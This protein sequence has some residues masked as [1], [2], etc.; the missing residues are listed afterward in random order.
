MY[1]FKPL[2]GEKYAE[3]CG[4]EGLKLLTSEKI[5]IAELRLRSNI[6]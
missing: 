4:S 1:N 2:H 5:A 3:N 6:S